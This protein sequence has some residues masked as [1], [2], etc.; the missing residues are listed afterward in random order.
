MGMQNPVEAG[1]RTDVEP[2]IRQYGHDLPWWQRRK[3]ALV[4]DEQYPFL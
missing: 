3:L 4:S 1:L 2:A